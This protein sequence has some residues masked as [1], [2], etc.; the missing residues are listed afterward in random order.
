MQSSPRQSQEPE[1]P[2]KIAEIEISASIACHC[3]VMTIDHLG[4]IL[5]RHGSGSSLGSIKLHRTKCAAV[6]KNCI[7]PA[8]KEELKKD[9]FNKKYVVMIDEST[10]VASQKLLCVAVS[11]VSDSVCPVTDFL[12]LIPVVDTTAETLYTTLKDELLRYGMNMSNCIG[13][14]SD[15]ASVMVGKNNSMWT[16]IKEDSPHCSS[17]YSVEMHLPLLGTMH[18]ACIRRIASKLRISSQRD[19]CLVFT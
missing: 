8:I 10:D 2:I 1:N 9:I 6:I 17:L 18:S 5:V 15:G 11:Y 3:S 16:R 7:A 19:S 12:G 14:A 13:F 4:E